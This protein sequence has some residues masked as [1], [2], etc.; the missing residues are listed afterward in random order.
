LER[1]EHSTARLGQAQPAFASVARRFRSVE[2]TALEEAVQHAAQVTAIQAEL[3][4][5]LGGGAALAVR[6]LVQHAYFGQRK[7]AV[8]VAVVQ[9]ADAFGVEA[10]EAADSI[11]TLLELGG[12]QHD[13]CQCQ[14]IT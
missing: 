1:L 11:D 4:R 9:D 2:K 13:S 14:P 8:Q 5:Q 7:L 6:Q 10:I 12:N 3:A